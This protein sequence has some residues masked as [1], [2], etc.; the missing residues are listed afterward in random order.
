MHPV[1]PAGWQAPGLAE[2]KRRIASEGWPALPL[3]DKEKRRWLGIL[4]EAVAKGLL[5]PKPATRLAEHVNQ[6]GTL[7]A[8][9][10]DDTPENR[11]LVKREQ[12][13]R[14][15]DHCL[16]AAF[17]A[18]GLSKR[19]A[20]GD[21]ETRKAVERVQ[22]DPETRALVAELQAE[23]RSRAWRA[24]RMPAVRGD[25]PAREQV[26]AVPRAREHGAGAV[27]RHRSQRQRDDGSDSDPP[28][29]R[30]GGRP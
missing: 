26:R 28:L 9:P 5:S 14:K 6:G 11:E 19:M 1:A 13:N 25:R 7:D 15:A 29:T 20:P 17:D 4:E 8:I 12:E 2:L 3:E 24:A 23:L 30:A 18:V 27:R 21:E 16:M 22:D 10:L